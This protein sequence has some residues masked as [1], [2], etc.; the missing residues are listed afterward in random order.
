MFTTLSDIGQTQD[1]KKRIADLERLR[2][3]QVLTKDRR[4]IVE[5]QQAL[6]QTKADAQRRKIERDA[7]Q[8]ATFMTM[9]SQ[10][11]LNAKRQMEKAA[12]RHREE[13]NM[14][15]HVF[16]NLFADVMDE[17]KK[18]HEKIQLDQ[19]EKMLPKHF[20]YALEPEPA[21][22]SDDEEVAPRAKKR[23]EPQKSFFGSIFS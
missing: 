23:V 18:Y 5:A 15:K 14:R 6:L 16:E 22:D 7:A 11:E 4:R 8:Q 2:E 1:E 21:R 3:Q 12:E 19:S 20:K 10:M 9:A 17:C 13:E